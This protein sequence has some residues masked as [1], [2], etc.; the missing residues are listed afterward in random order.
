MVYIV[1]I[2]FN[3]NHSIPCIGAKGSMFDLS[4]EASVFK[5]Q[6]LT[7]STQFFTPSLLYS[8]YYFLGRVVVVVV[9][10]TCQNIIQNRDR[11]RRVSGDEKGEESLWNWSPWK[12]EEP[13][14]PSIPS[15]RIRWISLPGERKLLRLSGQ[16]LSWPCL[17]ITF[18][19]TRFSSRTI[20]S[21]IV[22][23]ISR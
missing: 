10:A 15:D 12:Q 13:A 22:P 7:K 19:H 14:N 2:V 23:I 11:E 21:L 18:E 3:V 20:R 16:Q 4:F 17:R 6:N 1:I 5:K 9:V 8:R